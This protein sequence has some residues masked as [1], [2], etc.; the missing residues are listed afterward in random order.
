MV[1]DWNIRPYTGTMDNEKIGKHKDKKAKNDEN[2]IA[3]L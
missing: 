1:G 2:D 3:I